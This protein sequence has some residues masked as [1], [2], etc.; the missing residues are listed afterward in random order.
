M[1]C[2]LK[3]FTLL[4]QHVLTNKGSFG[5]RHFGEII[6]KKLYYFSKEQDFILFKSQDSNHKQLRAK[7]YPSRI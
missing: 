5:M 3:P 4:K 1:K 7:Q 2:S 6:L